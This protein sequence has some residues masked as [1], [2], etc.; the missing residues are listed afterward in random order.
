MNGMDD[1][2]E[3]WVKK[4]GEGIKRMWIRVKDEIREDV[5]VQGRWIRLLGL[6]R[7]RMGW[8]GD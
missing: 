7:I 6:F 3:D 5:V 2:E 8:K 4:W 1:D